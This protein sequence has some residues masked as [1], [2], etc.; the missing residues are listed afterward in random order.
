MYLIDRVGKWLGI[1]DAKQN[2]SR[3]LLVDVLIMCSFAVSGALLGGLSSSWSWP[4]GLAF[5][6]LWSIPVVVGF[7][8]FII[9]YFWRKRHERE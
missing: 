9:D 7:E 1:E 2:N 3:L 8:V 4:H 5:G 6:V